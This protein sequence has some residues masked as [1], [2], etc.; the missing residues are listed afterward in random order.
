M[1]FKCMMHVLYIYII[2]INSSL[3]FVRLKILVKQSRGAASN[4]CINTEVNHNCNN[5]GDQ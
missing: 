1:C 2:R 3:F 4:R 5:N